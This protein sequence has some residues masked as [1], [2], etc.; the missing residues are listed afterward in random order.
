MNIFNRKQ[1]TELEKK[2][3]TTELER[4]KYISKAAEMEVT[5]EEVSKLE[6]SI[7][8]GCTKGPWC[9]ACE[10]AKTIHYIEYRGG[11]GFDSLGTIYVCSKGKSCENFVQKEI[12]DD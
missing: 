5:L 1:I 4:D 2:L 10:F 11:H 9:R 7:P 12:N 3:H 6:E 8:E